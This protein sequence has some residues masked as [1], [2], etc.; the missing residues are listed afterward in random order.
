MGRY[1]IIKIK[2]WNKIYYKIQERFLWFWFW[3]DET[4]WYYWFTYT[5]KTLKE[6]EKKIQDRLNFENKTEKIIKTYN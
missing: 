2:E 1:R 5:Y 3:T 4:D 6:A